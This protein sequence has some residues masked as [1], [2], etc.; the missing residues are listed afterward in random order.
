MALNFPKDFRAGDSLKFL[1]ALSNYQ[2]PEW[3]LT[4]ALFN[5]SDSI[6]ITS[7]ADAERHSFSVAPSDTTNWPHGEYRWQAFV[8]DGTD[9]FTVGTGLVDVLPNLAGSLNGQLS[10]VERTLKALETSI[11][12]LAS[13][14]HS[15]V[16]FNGRSFT[17]REMGDLIAMRDKY[18]SELTRIKR[19]EKVRSGLY[20]AGSVRVRF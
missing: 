12:S 17:H 16:Q 8:T 5:G 15:T 7:T 11:E 1:D 9:R 14:T 19:A 20:K 13:K 4:Y 2:A 10:H 3:T 6:K 18:K